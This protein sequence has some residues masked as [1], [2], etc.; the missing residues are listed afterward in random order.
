MRPTWA[1]IDLG[2]IKH[3]VHQLQKL[4]APSLLCAVVKADAYGH[5]AVPVARAA[6]SAGVEWLAVALV[7]EGI[8]LREAGIDA[9]ILLLSEPRPLEM[10]EVAAYALTPTVY[11]GEG[12]AAAAAAA[13]QADKIIPV[14]LKVDTGMHRVGV[15]PDLALTL[16]KAIQEKPSLTLDGV[17]THCAVADEAENPF[18]AKQLTV[19]QRTIDEIQSEGINSTM[20]HAANSALALNKPEGRYD[21]VR[22]GLAIYG[23]LPAG[24]ESSEIDLQP[25]MRVRS[26][27][28]FV[29]EIGAGEGVSYGLSWVSE[30]KTNIATIP[31]GYADGLRRDAGRSGGQVL[32]GGQRYP[33]VGDV[34]MDQFLVDCGTGD[35]IP[36]DEVVVLG[37]QGDDQIT[38]TEWAKIYKTITYEVICGIESRVPRKFI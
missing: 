8:T 7:E 26:E 9:P 35:V 34:T 1:D 36:G 17:W 27:V 25:A 37:P 30:K 15:Q 22:C 13:K 18:T 28:S 31:M 3:N 33:I 24:Y 14:H 38:A 20:Y 5:G 29:K 4:V 10:V 19:F 32:I 16:A 21:L 11:S 23:L 12:I 6:I 2:A